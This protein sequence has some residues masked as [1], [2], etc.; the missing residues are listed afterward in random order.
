[1]EEIPSMEVCNA[2]RNCIV[3]EYCLKR[4]PFN[5]HKPSPNAFIT[6]LELRMK[7]YYSQFLRSRK[8]YTKK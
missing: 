5:P 2:I 6:K 7:K 8:V 3:R 4:G 1:M